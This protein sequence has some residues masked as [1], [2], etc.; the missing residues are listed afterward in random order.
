MAFSFTVAFA[1][2][3][4]MG[5][6]FIRDL[7]IPVTGSGML[8]FLNSKASVGG[9]SWCFCPEHLGPADPRNESPWKSVRLFLC[10]L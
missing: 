1:D 6:P 10:L 3:A 9:A 7:S 5:G 8:A 4:R 2:D